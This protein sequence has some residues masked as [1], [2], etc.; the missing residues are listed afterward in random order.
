VLE[1]EETTQPKVTSDG[2][3]RGVYYYVSDEQLRVFASLTPTQRLAWLE[4]MRE[5]TA[6]VAPPEAQRWWRRFRNGR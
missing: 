3:V 5:F 2:E 4:E 6:L 1:R